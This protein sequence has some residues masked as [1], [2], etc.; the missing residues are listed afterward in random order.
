MSEKCLKYIPLKCTYF[1]F[2][3]ISF[4]QMETSKSVYNIYHW[5]VLILFS[6]P[7][8]QRK[9]GVMTTM[10]MRKGVA[11]G[12]R[13]AASPARRRRSRRRKMRR[14]SRPN[15]GARSFPRRSSRPVRTPIRMA[16]ENSKSMLGEL[17]CFLLFF[18]NLLL[19]LSG[20]SDDDLYIGKVSKCEN[21]PNMSGL[22][23]TINPNRGQKQFWWNLSGKS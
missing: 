19:S 11:R 21:H 2:F 1:L 20:Y 3:F 6:L 18:R 4:D 9:E 22:L 17:Y 10:T 14:V 8:D 15:R 12:V 16:V 23:K 7:S 5:I 13:R